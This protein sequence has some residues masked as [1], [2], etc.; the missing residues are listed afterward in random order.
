MKFNLFIK[1]ALT[2]LLLA[3][4]HILSAQVL[5]ESEANKSRIVLGEQLRLKITVSSPNG[6][7]PF[8][9]TDSIPHFEKLDST[10]IDTIS[11][12]EG[13]TMVQELTL[14]SFDSGHWSIPPFAVEIG[15][16]RY[17]SDSIPIDV[18][19]SEAGVP[20]NYHDIQD[21][22]DVKKDFNWLLWIL[23][24]VT[25][26]VLV[27]LFLRWRKRKKE[28]AGFKR[29]AHLSPLDEAMKL[30]D[31][32]EAEQLE[33]K[34]RYTRLTYIFRIFLQRKRKMNA[35]RK[36]T[37]ELLLQLEKSSLDQDQYVKLAQT[38]RASN[39]VKFAKYEPGP[40]EDREHIQVIRTSIQSLNS[41]AQ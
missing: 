18:T 7:I 25:L 34:I 9:N 21:I 11:N 32:L 24:A 41:D 10:R 38:L 5:V 36:T 22:A 6:N 8:V 13:F 23:I 2:V 35:F 19:Y 14:T 39:L 16:K 20:E 30:L 4:S 40:E 33:P 31:E 26:I 37:Y 12:S 15:D 28:R 29:Y 1:T 17:T 27:L 3:G